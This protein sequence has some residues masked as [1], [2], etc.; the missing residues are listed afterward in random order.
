MIILSEEYKRGVTE[1]QNLCES[2][3]SRKDRC[4]YEG[5]MPD[6]N[7]MKWTMGELLEGIKDEKK[8]QQTALLLHNQ[9]VYYRSL[10]ETTRLSYVGSFDRWSYPVIAAV[11]PNLIAHD[12]VSIQA[13]NGPTSMVFFMK[14]LY[15]V[16]KGAAKAGQD[17]LTNPSTNFGSKTIEGESIGTGDGATQVFA[18][19]LS[20]VPVH[21]G[22]MLFS[23]GDTQIVTD[24]GAG[25]L[26]GSGTGTINYSTGAYS[27]TWTAAPTAGA[28]VVVT[29]DYDNEGNSLQA[30]LDF[31]ITGSP[32]TA[33]TD[34]L[35]SKLS[36]ESAMDFRVV[37]GKSADVELMSAQVSQAKFEIDQKVINDCIRIATNQ[38]VAW[39]ATPPAGVSYTEHKL[40][41]VDT[42]VGA[43]NKIYE[44]TQRARGDWIV[45]GV[46][47]CNVIE[48]L[49]GFK[50][51][52]K[53]ISG[54]GI[55]HIGTL[56]GTWEVY[57][58]SYMARATY[59]MGHKG[60]EM[61]DTGYIF[62]PY[63]MFEH[64]PPVTLTDFLTRFGI[65]SRYG[66]KVVDGGFYCTGTCTSLPV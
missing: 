53:K 26:S 60:E 51:N 33:V 49:P 14:F 24:N 23:D 17:I 30:E 63:Q 57:I 45:A 62:S 6:G 28:A 32:V 37:H 3:V 10:E 20:W 29:Y 52:G 55:Q 18:G 44:T 8:R 7:T 50:G 47:V 46:G 4:L 9:N 48:T 1:N 25:V 19:T 5:K 21:S 56:N 15:G 66:K 42:L 11:F 64:V 61:W 39:S 16:T 34:K 59:C 43:S 12:L 31:V 27:I 13:M 41:I 38:Q 54:R 40:S 36:L 2:L 65:W 58:N 35:I 22:T